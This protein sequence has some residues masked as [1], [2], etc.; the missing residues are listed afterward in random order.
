MQMYRLTISL[1]DQGRSYGICV[2]CA[3][4][5]SYRRKHSLGVFREHG[6]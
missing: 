1:R 3:S 5:P 4:G 6:G 2:M